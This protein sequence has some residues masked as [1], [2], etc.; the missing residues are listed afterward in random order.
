M[1]LSGREN[2]DGNKGGCSHEWEEPG[3]KGQKS[4]WKFGCKGIGQSISMT[5]QRPVLE[6]AP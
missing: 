4:E 2:V 1:E 3:R 6:E 5:F